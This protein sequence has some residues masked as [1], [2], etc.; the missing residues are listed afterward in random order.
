M[1]LVQEKGVTLIDPILVNESLLAIDI[2]LKGGLVLSDSFHRFNFWKMPTQ[3]EEYGTEGKTR[4]RLDL[5]R[6]WDLIAGSTADVIVAEDVRQFPGQ[7]IAGGGTFMIQKGV[8]IGMAAACCKRIEFIE[9]QAWIH[10]YT[11]KRSKFFVNEA[12]NKSKD[13]WKAYLLE[14]A[15]GI[16]TDEI[17]GQLDLSTADA[18]LMWN[19]QAAKM[20]GQPLEKMTMQLKFSI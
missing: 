11:Y 14:L 16:A 9:P 3:K 8:L 2:G 10:C 18:F 4:D 6:L 15:Q 19:Y 12:G 1:E 20:I 17:K 13:L 5:P 7:G